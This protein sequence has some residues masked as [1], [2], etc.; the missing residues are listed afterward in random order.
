[1]KTTE[2]HSTSSNRQQQ[3]KPTHFFE[4]ESEQGFFS[5]RPSLQTKPFFPG[6]ANS[7]GIQ[8]KAQNN[9]L[10]IGRPNDQY[11]QEADRVADRVISQ[12][13]NNTGTVENSG[14]NTPPAV[15]AKC[16]HCEQKEQLQKKEE[17]NTEPEGIRRK[18]I[19]ESEGDDPAAGNAGGNIQ[20]KC[21]ECAEEEEGMVRRMPEEGHVG[22][23]DNMIQRKCASCEAAEESI[24]PKAAQ[25]N[26]GSNSG[27]GNFSS[28]LESTKGGGQ[29]LSGGTRK[30][31]ETSIGA[32]FSGVR[33]HNNSESAEL[34]QQIGAKAFTHG[35]DIY[36]N[37]GQYDPGSESGKHLLVHELPHTVQQGKSVR[38]KPE[39]GDAVPDI[40]A[41]FWDSVKTAAEKNKCKEKEKTEKKGS[42]EQAKSEETASIEK[43]CSEKNPKPEQP[44]KGKDKP[45]GDE[46]PAAVG[47]KAGA[48]VGDRQQNAPPP[49]KGQAAVPE[50]ATADAK[51]AAGP[52]GP[53]P[54][55]KA[56]GGTPAKATPAKAA[57]P[58]AKKEGPQN[59]P[60]APQKGGGKK[61]R[62]GAK[63]KKGKGKKTAGKKGALPDTVKPQGLGEAASPKLMVERETQRARA[64]VATGGLMN[65]R[66]HATGLQFTP[67]QYLQPAADGAG[68]QARAEEL[69]NHQ[70]SSVLAGGFIHSAAFKLNAFIDSAMQKSQM[71][72]ATVAARQG[73]IKEKIKTRRA[74]V[75]S[76]TAKLKAAALIKAAKAQ[77]MINAQHQTTV[78]QIEAKAL[79]STLMVQ[80]QYALKSQELAQKKAAQLQ[81]IDATYNKAYG[82]I[83][84]IGITVGGEA[85]ARAEK[86]A[87]AYENAEGSN[88]A[89]V[90][91]KVKNKIKDGFWDGYLTYNRYKARAKS[92]RET[93]K[94]FREGM[95]EE[96]QAQADKLV[97][98][99][100]KDL[101]KVHAA[102]TQAA[103]SLK[104]TLDNALKGIATQ[105]Q[106]SLA[107]AAA[108]QAQ[109][110][111]AVQSTL[112]TTL[113]KL[114]EQE[115]IQLQFIKDFGIR[116]SMAIER[117]AEMAITSLLSGANEAA[118]KLLTLITG[119][120]DMVLTNEAPQ[121]E[122]VR[123][124]VQVMSTHFDGAL[125]AVMTSFE[126]GYSA[127]DQGLGGGGQQATSALDTYADTEIAASKQTAAVFTQ[128]VN[129]CV[130]KTIAGYA[131]LLGGFVQQVD[132]TV[133]TAMS[134]YDAVLTG[135]DGLFTQINTEITNRIKTNK[136]NIEGG[137]RDSVEK[138]LDQ[139]VCVE[140]EKAA[141]AVQPW[142]KTV[143][144]ILLV[145]VV[146]VIMIVVLG[147]AGGLLATVVQGA[148][149]GAVAGAVIQ[150]GNNLIDG[151]KW[152]DGVGKAIILGAIGGAF[153]GLG[154]H[155][156]QVLVKGSQAASLT[157]G[158]HV[159]RGGIEMAFDAAGG[160]LG[161]LAVGNPITLQG[162]LIGAGIGA[163]V[164]LGTGSFS[165]LKGKISNRFKPKTGAPDVKVSG[166]KGSGAD[167]SA[168]K[169]DG[170]VPGSSKKPAKSKNSSDG[171]DSTPSG[172]KKQVEATGKLKGEELSPKQLR[173]ELHEGF[174]NG[175][176][177]RGK[178]E[179]D[180][181]VELPN[182]H[183][184][185]RKKNGKWCRFS[186]EFC[187]LDDTLDG[188]RPRNY[189]EFDPETQRLI[190]EATAPT[191]K[192]LRNMDPDDAGIKA[193]KA[194]DPTTSGG[195]RVRD[196]DYGDLGT[197]GS[198]CF[199]GS[200][201]VKTK[202]GDIPISEIKAGDIVKTW[203]VRKSKMELKP[204]TQVHFTH[205][206]HL[207]DIFLNSGE[208]I[209]S[210]GKHP[211][212]VEER[213]DWIEAKHLESGMTLRDLEG[214][215]HQI[216][217]VSFSNVESLAYNLTVAGNSNF[218]V[219]KTGIL[220]HNTARKKRPN[221]KS[222]NTVQVDF[223]LITDMA[224]GKVYV[225]QA[226]VGRG[227]Y[228]KRYQEHIDEG[229]KKP[230]SWKANMEKKFRGRPRFVVQQ[231]G[232]GTFNPIGAAITERHLAIKHGAIGTNGL[233]KHTILKVTTYQK[234]KHLFIGPCL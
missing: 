75:Q 16:A 13:K 79:Q 88:D 117:D 42:K 17:E 170:N 95:V 5:D 138:D 208:I 205:P 14:N 46:K 110:L 39:D 210:T 51:A 83:R 81:A 85:K 11:E 186:D 217:K 182:G 227:G 41:A 203:N 167:V 77:V 134:T 123:A 48:S 25:A 232:R 183:T 231:L 140:A 144:K 24:Q 47:A 197:S 98:D 109:M 120:R 115:A 118:A 73:E 97:C 27:G 84:N 172:R 171:A 86:H 29:G 215:L 220:V 128:A 104:C 126:Q 233:N 176:V 222:I 40:Q 67:V 20:R 156:A 168:P 58:P 216:G 202:L 192:L 163:G 132:N 209:Q 15:Q 188:F 224:T 150:I 26:A 37:K 149:A 32:D 92:A 226:E 55:A 141:K 60:D 180:L 155:F 201:L 18:P 228:T 129:V 181:E 9:G 200:T 12:Q 230:R 107:N 178:G 184:Y 142:W 63:G 136:E 179:Y 71:I 185:K 59:G 49:E 147:P 68:N 139:K 161:D 19:F 211:F 99:K 7:P 166:G 189:E 21:A 53:Q 74:E 87:V 124:Q 133:A 106:S 56:A 146:I 54:G 105:R 101:E 159:L 175:K 234:H 61:Q 158:Q 229:R 6:G 165:F 225:G 31:M 135:L 195:D 23:R 2:N 174:A 130:A 145:I 76:N 143:L 157:I 154:G 119:F 214:E 38:R 3:A 30:E 164:S 33:I 194:D 1:M 57:P 35:S 52:C 70:L 193:A 62:K 103:E 206:T 45:K 131:K 190:D 207:F 91:K 96:S 89:E 187:I 4:P 69:A 82:E 191:D 153:G 65:S 122:I 36:F 43:E 102:S 8:A 116:Q 72:K 112:T 64:M 198:I 199:P 114:T 162:V 151:K 148:V 173:D 223:Y 108:L 94:Q 44:P 66:V 213:S 93:G 34:S 111:T 80:M 50:D 177:R 204:V 113:S 137:M 169:S 152:S 28:R 10:R 22:G 160:I 100:P 218:F 78:Q 219:G 121:S 212:W 127:A 221:F 125:S 196:M 90:K